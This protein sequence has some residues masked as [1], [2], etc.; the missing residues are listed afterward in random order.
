MDLLTGSDLH[1]CMTELEAS[2][3]QAIATSA[4]LMRYAIATHIVHSMLPA[5]RQVTTPVTEVENVPHARRFFRPQWVAF[6][7]QDNLLV[8]SVDDAEAYIAS[9]QRY[10]ALLQAA[11]TLAPYIV[12]D[13]DYQLKRSGMFGQ[14]VNQGRALA[15]Y[16]TSEAIRI[17]RK[18]LAAGNLNRGL[19]LSLP[20]FDDQRL[21]L[22]YREIQVI[23]AGRILFVAAF[24]V[25]ASRMEQIKVEHDPELSSSTR[26]HLLEELK[27]LELA[28]DPNH[29]GKSR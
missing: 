11:A 12:A 17:I 26:K 7:D 28:F 25:I 27:S 2:S 15:R 10:M 13:K 14:L 3:D 21:E 1:Q 29:G 18:R 5:G 24:V 19:S 4:S 20:Y 23:P 6:D 16:K 22:R 9:I 8:D